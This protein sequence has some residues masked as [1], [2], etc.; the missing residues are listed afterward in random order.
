VVR[1]RLG[2]SKRSLQTLHLAMLAETEDQTEGTGRFVQG[3]GFRVCGKTGTAERDDPRPDGVKRNTTWF[4]SF[5]PY[6]APRYAVV[7]M[8]E[9]GQS[10]GTSCVPI[11]RE[12]YVALKGYETRHPPTTLAQNN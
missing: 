6:E 3:C 2:V 8:V 4:A 1:D 12:I 7:V 5:A 11:A 10:G 9:D